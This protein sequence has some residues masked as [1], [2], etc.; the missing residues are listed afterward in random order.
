MIASICVK[1]SKNANRQ[2]CEDNYEQIKVELVADDGLDPISHKHLRA[3]EKQNR[4]ERIFEIAKFV[5]HS[6]KHEK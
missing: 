2:D 1:G 4:S 3:N 5:E 6:G